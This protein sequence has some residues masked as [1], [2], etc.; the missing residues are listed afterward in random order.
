MF[1]RML[2]S[3][4]PSEAP[5]PLVQGLKNEHDQVWKMIQASIIFLLQTT[6]CL[7]KVAIKALLTVPVEG[8][9]G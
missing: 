9:L 1:P 7:D 2:A 5:V 3:T 8:M 6:K 4:G